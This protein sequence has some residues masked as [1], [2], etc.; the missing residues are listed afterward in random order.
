[1]RTVDRRLIV[2]NR[3]LVI[4]SLLH[5]AAYG[6]VGLDGYEWQARPFVFVWMLVPIPLAY[7][8]ATKLART[9]ASMAV[10]LVGLLVALAFVAWVYWEITWGTTRY[11]ESLSGLLFIFAPLYQY[12]WL[13]LV[14][15]I[16]AVVS[17]TTAAR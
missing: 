12:G 17:R 10:V 2:A 1:M 8:L 4:A 6:A 5:A 16:A 3:V 7:W 13:A 9:N 11:T 14:L 15:L